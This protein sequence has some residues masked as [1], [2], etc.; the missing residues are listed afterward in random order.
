M[1]AFLCFPFLFAICG[2]AQD[3]ADRVTI[4]RLIGSLNEPDA[5]PVFTSDADRGEAAHLANLVK[6]LGDMRRPWSETAAP[7]IFSKAVRFI[8][9][10]VALVDALVAPY[11]MVLPTTPALFV[12]KKVGPDWRIA[13]FRE[14]TGNCM[15]PGPFAR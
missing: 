12:M 13:S 4:E 8:T 1:K 9:P 6:Q 3:A 10:D 2:L 14:L 11:G 7:R 5:K 15:L